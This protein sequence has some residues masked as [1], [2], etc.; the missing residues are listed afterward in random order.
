MKYW[1]LI[2]VGV[3]T[4]TPTCVSE[5]DQSSSDETLTKFHEKIDNDIGKLDNNID[6]ILQYIKSMSE[7]DN[8]APAGYDYTTLNDDEISNVLSMLIEF[9]EKYFSDTPLASELEQR[10]MWN[11]PKNVYK[12]AINVK[13]K[14]LP[15][16]LNP[17]YWFYILCAEEPADMIGKFIVTA[18]NSVTDEE[19][20][21]IEQ[22]AD[23]Y[24]KT[25]LSDDIESSE[26]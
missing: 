19:Y 14:G 16:A 22:H 11:I 20:E 17:L 9:E 18:V 15:D 12:A 1:E 4:S 23:D 3:K 8:S 13:D 24:D 10:F 26:E 6:K 7:K 25:Y 5:D 2:N 21:V